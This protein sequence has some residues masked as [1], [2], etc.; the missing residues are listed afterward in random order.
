MTD[1]THTPD[2]VDSDVPDTPPNDEHDDSKTGK[3][4]RRAQTAEAERDQLRAQLDAAR[5]HIV[6]DTCGLSRPA[7]L[8]A[9]GVDP[10]TLFDNDGRLDRAALTAAV[11][12]AVNTLGV[13]RAPRTPKPDPSA[14]ST[15]DK[16]E[17]PSWSTL[18]DRAKRR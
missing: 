16:D 11:D 15:G 2:N 14:G 10:N 5:R 9:A 17:Q 3:L 13:S 4:R 18:F 8:W 7:A 12:G 1:E 6:E